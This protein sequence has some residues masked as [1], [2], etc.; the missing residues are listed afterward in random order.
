MEAR[1]LRPVSL[2]YVTDLNGI[3]S[4]LGS[5]LIETATD[6]DYFEIVVSEAGT[7]TIQITN[8]PT[9]PNL[10]IEFELYDAGGSPIAAAAPAG[11]LDCTL[12]HVVTPG[13]YYV[14]LKADNEG[15]GSSGYTDYGSLG[16]YSIVATLPVPLNAEIDSPSVGRDFPA[17]RDEAAPFRN[18]QRR[19]AELAGDQCPPWW[20]CSVFGSLLALD[21]M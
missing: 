3:T 13:T 2:N 18:C 16:V 10:D 5:G 1:P 12:N 20:Q 21:S 15:S 6:L 9:D 11:D 19:Y 4:G 17:G 7:L 8:D 14:G